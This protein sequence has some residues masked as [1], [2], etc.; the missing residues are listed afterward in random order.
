[1]LTK[2][3]VEFDGSQESITLPV[4]TLKNL[5][6]LFG[7]KRHLALQPLTTDRE[8][9]NDHIKVRFHSTT[10]TAHLHVSLGDEAL[11][12]FVT[13]HKQLF[14]LTHDLGLWAQHRL[15]RAGRRHWTAC[16]AWHGAAIW[17]AP[18]SGTHWHGLGTALTH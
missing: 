3:G 16:A 2:P 14:G 5:L 6:Q 18:R 10:P 7:G 13:Q 9:V 12:L 8:T 1:M 17:D 15:F 11:A 4:Q